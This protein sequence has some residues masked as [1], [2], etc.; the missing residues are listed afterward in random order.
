MG[1]VLRHDGLLRD[2]LEGRMFGKRT[3][4]RRR[5]QLMDRCIYMLWVDTTSEVN[6][7][8]KTRINTRLLRGKVVF[9]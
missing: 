5:T 1:H 7:E 6:P 4:G 2:V 9:S 8:A 3:R